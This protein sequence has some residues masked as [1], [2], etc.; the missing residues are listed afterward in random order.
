MKDED[1]LDQFLVESSIKDFVLYYG[2]ENSEMSGEP[3]ISL[4]K[5]T[6]DQAKLIAS[7]NINLDEKIIQSLLVNGFADLENFNSINSIKAMFR[8]K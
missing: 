4:L 7:L 5:N 8:L 1:S 3:L 2:K 6:Y